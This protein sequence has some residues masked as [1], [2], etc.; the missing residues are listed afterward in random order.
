M[1][2]ILP[3]HIIFDPIWLYYVFLS[4]VTKIFILHIILWNKSEGSLGKSYYDYLHVE[5]SKISLV[6]HLHIGIV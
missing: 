3:L 4:I 2:V 5:S 1:T 6:F